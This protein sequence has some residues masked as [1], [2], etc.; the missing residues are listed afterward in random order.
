MYL[1]I[2]LPAGYIFRIS[3]AIAAED[4]KWIKNL[5]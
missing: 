2:I 5:A 3:T 4:K 1:K